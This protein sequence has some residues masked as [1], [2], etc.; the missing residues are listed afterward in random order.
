MALVG[1]AVS[2][3]RGEASG[4]LEGLAEWGLCHLKVLPFLAE[5]YI[6]KFTSKHKGELVLQ[7]ERK[8]KPSTHNLIWI[9]P[10]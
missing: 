10:T 6:I 9:M 4:G 1:E 3:F 8:E 5:R 2:V 7:A